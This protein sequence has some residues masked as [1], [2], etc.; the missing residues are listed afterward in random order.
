MRI[1]AKVSGQTEITTTTTKRI[2]TIKFVI[3]FSSS[4]FFMNVWE[5]LEAT[6]PVGC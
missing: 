4:L 2:E 6:G 1:V 5:N 3:I